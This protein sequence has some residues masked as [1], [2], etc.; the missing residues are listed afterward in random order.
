MTRAGLRAALGAALAALCA[1]GAG[2]QTPASQSEAQSQIAD[3]PRLE[4]AR[5]LY[6][7]GEWQQ[8]AGAAHGPAS[9]SPE[10]DYLEGMSLAHL[11]RW[12]EAR[13][14]FTVGGEKA[15]R[16]SR[17]AIERAGVEYRLKRF[18]EAK[19]DLRRGLR[20]APQDGYAA[21]FLATLYSL[22]GNTE[23]ALKYWNGAGKPRLASLAVTPPVKLRPQLLEKGV[24]YSPPT[25]LER[26]AW[27]AAEARLAA[28]E[29]FPQRR[30]EL[31]PAEQDG[32]DE[33]LVLTERNGWG[34]G[35]L[36]GA[37]ALLSGLPYE[38]VY[39]SWYNISGDAVNFNGLA[40]WDDQKR[41]AYAE[42][43]F[44]PPER[45]GQRIRFFLDARNENW[46]L[47]KTFSGS[48]APLTNLN[49]RRLAAG[50]EFRTVMGARSSW[51]AGAQIITRRF[52]NTPTPANPAAAQFFTNGTSLDVWTRA[53]RSILRIPEHRL[54]VE[55]A[56]S[57]EFGRGFTHPLGRF[58]G[59]GGDVQAR[60]LPRASGD[61]DE[62][63][64]RLR[65]ADMLGRVPLDQLFQLGVERDNDLWLRGHSGLEA[66]RK[67]NAPLG[68]RYALLNSEFD[69][70]IY[71]GAFF[72]VQAGPLLDMGA[73]ADP[74]GLFGS[75]MWLVDAGAA[76]KIRVLGAVTVTLSYGR[77]LRNGG[78]AF[79]ATTGR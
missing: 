63:I 24:G 26:D 48:S 66:G 39:P 64:V 40:R 3:G 70:A 68:R 52:R 44:P 37:L 47:A 6:S 43:S 35:W 10:L 28:L 51:L 32:F 2:A 36:A 77:D 22:D 19:R 71:R 73:V 75:R 18:A 54:T 8:A 79:F 33:R 69:K 42:I 14:A 9:Q 62:L 16:D 23:A 74:S 41:R 72:R 17:F 49:L 58:G 55:A 31:R 15:P 67:G 50:A 4:R 20:F 34:G 57:A 45:P 11:G 38:T 1:C 60:W 5:Q 7:A 56:A 53:E 25:I 61:D 78:G 12:E 65:A 29:I 30:T 13:A 76:A 27:L 59:L 46:N 21:D